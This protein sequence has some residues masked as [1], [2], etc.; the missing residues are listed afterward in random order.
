MQTIRFGS[1]VT[2]T[3]AE[4]AYLRAR[5]AFKIPTLDLLHGRYAPFVI[6]VLSIVFTAD[7]PT[8]AVADA[9]VEV[10][11][12]LDE[13]RAAGYEDEG[14]GL[15]STSGREVCR[16]WVRVGW[17]GQQIEGDTEVYRCTAHA[18]RALEIA[19]LTGGSTRVSQSRVR[20]LLDAVDRL[21]GDADADPARRLAR[22]RAE[23]AALDEQITALE[24]ND[25]APITDDELVEEA[26]N[27]LHLARSLPADFTRVAESIKAM[28]RDVIRDLRRDERPTGDVL[29]EYLLRGQ[30]VMQSTR[31]GE[32]FAGALRVLGDP[33]RIDA[34]VDQLHE[35]VSR[36]FAQLLDEAQRAELDT[37]GRRMELGVQEVL[38]AQRRASHMIA[39]QVRTHDP[40]RDRQV[41]ELLRDVI[42]GLQSWTQSRTPETPV[43]PLRRLP[44]AS[45]GHLRQSLSD[46]RPPEPPVPLADRSDDAV[47][48]DADT[49]AWGGPRYAELEAYV[50]GLG[51]E[52]DLGAAF[53]GAEDD[54]R[55]PV[56]LLGL[57]EIAHRNGMVESEEVS[58]VE[59]L[60]PDGTTR[61]FAFAAVTAQATP[62]PK[63]KEQADD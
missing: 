33:E 63:S 51:A 34:L 19:D 15:P 61:R 13:L 6:A 2:G 60:R 43:E 22:L 26:E 29:R 54:T 58:V 23:R 5:A 45:I 48:L 49:R 14:R 17:L 38:T 24:N 41:D 47:F 37:V 62:S 1:S 50:A 20:T 30:Q 44:I 52:F 32:A 8:V 36:P 10:G 35:L 55:R 53:V 4:A 42:A 12:I 18:V 25:A 31:E 57:L 56:D 11:E 16:Y 46:I 9:H 40:A 7:R 59:A 39:S 28:Q 3:R 21:A 27:V